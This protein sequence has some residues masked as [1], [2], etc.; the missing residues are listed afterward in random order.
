MSE[1][2]RYKEESL[3]KELESALASEDSLRED[4]ASTQ[5]LAGLN[6]KLA[7]ALQQRLTVAEQ[8]VE[9]L[10]AFAQQIERQQGEPYFSKLAKAALKPAAEG[11]GS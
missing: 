7:I 1:V 2:K 8:R 3:L 5:E 10:T 9:R 6:A 11:E 4:L